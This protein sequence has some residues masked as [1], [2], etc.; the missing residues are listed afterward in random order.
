MGGFGRALEELYLELHCTH[1]SKRKL[2]FIPV[3]RCVVSAV[4]AAYPAVDFRVNAMSV[5][6]M[7]VV[8]RRVVDDSSRFGSSS[9]DEVMSSGLLRLRNRRLECPYVLYLLLPPELFGP[10]RTY[11]PS[12]KREQEDWKPW[13][14]WEHFNCKVRVLK[15]M[16]CAREEVPLHWTDLHCGA[17]FGQGCD[18]VVRELPR[19]FVCCL[20]Q[21]TTKSNGFSRD[22]CSCGN[23]SRFLYLP[24]D[25]E[26]PASFVCMEDTERGFFHEVHRYKCTD[27]DLSLKALGEAKSSA[28]GPEDLFLL[29]STGD[30]SCDVSSLRSFAVVDRS[31]WQTYYGPFAARI[32]PSDS[33]CAVP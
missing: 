19:T 20:E 1:E 24:A 27:E 31:C 8:A 16:A 25:H 6:F 12:E 29:Y 15:S 4:Q 17:R 14:G 2:E 18:R 7:A 10:W 5:A 13:Q 30:V 9:L 32:V 22:E 3:F 28:A 21:M 11:V 26:S 23:E 33:T